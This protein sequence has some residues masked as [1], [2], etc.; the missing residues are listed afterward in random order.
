V[1]LGLAAVAAAISGFVLFLA[2][3]GLCTAMLCCQ[4]LFGRLAG[5][6]DCAVARKPILI[7]ACTGFV[8]VVEDQV[9]GLQGHSDRQNI[10]R[11]H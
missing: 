11:V 2:A 5:C 4:R 8:Q 7:T 3:Q 10:N 1:Q 6:S 9:T